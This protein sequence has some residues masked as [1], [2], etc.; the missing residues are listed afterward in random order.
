MHETVVLPCPE[1]VKPFRQNKETICI[2]KGI[3]ETI[4]KFWEKGFIS[5]GCCQGDKE[6]GLNPD[7]VLPETYDE[8]KIQEVKIFLSSI[9]DREWN[10]L[11]WQWKLV[12]V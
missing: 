9:D 1:Q 5:L 8:V 10:L 6:K 7:I 4:S 12:R 11:Q 3:A 2:D